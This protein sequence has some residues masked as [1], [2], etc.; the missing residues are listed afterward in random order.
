MFMHVCIY[1]YGV[2]PVFCLLSDDYNR[3]KLKQTRNKSDYINASYVIVS[4][5]FLLSNII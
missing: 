5:L 1:L 2:Y 4:A 3:V